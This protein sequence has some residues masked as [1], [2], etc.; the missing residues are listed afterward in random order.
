MNA[1]YT[2]NRSLARHRDDVATKLNVLASGL[3]RTDFR[4]DEITL[5][6]DLKDLFDLVDHGHARYG[7]PR[8]NGGLFNL[9]AN[10]FLETKA[11][12]D[13]Y[14]ARVLDQLGRA[15][16]PG[17]PDLG[18]FRVDY[19]D[20]AIQQLGSVYE[21]LL[22]L[23]PRYANEEMR[24]V[25]STRGG[26][27]IEKVI[28]AAE[29]A[30]RGFKPTGTAYPADSIYL[31]T[32]KGERRK[33]GSYYT[34]DHIVGR[35]VD[36]ALGSRCRELSEAIGRE[37]AEARTALETAAAAER[38]QWEAK[39]QALEGSFVDRVLGLKVLDPAM[40]SG[41]F[42]IRACQ[43][44]A[45]EIAT[46]PFTS[47]PAADALN[48]DESTITY[49]KRRVAE[50]C[51]YGVD[52]NRM[53][54]ELAKLALWL[55]TVA[56]DAP[57]T[58]LDHH[59]RHGDS[60]IGARVAHLGGVPGEE[61]ILQGQFTEEVERALPSLLEP[62][63]EIRGLPSDTAEHVK[64]KGQIFERRFLPAQDRFEKT[65]NLWCAEVLESGV[66]T[67]EQYADTVRAIG[68][69]QQF[70]T[71]LRSEWC[72]GALRSL[73][74]KGV[75]PF[76]WEL[77]YPDVFLSP[78]DRRRS[79]FDVIIGNPP[80]DVLAELEAGREI[81]HLK[82]HIGLDPSL[83]PSVVGKNNL[84]KV[85]ICRAV[86]LLADGGYLGFIV[87]MPLL[88][89]EQARGIRQLLLAS[90]AFSEIH[91]FPQK[92][93]A[94]RRVFR[95]AK[96]STAV[97]V[98]RKMR[99]EEKDG[100]SQ[101]RSHV[102]PAQFIESESPSLVLDES[103]IELY[104]PANL[105]ILSCSQADWDLAKRIVRRPGIGRLGRFCKSYQGE[106]N[107]TNEGKRAGVLYG[108]PGL[109]RKLVLRGSN[110]CLYVLRKASQGE[111]IYI[112]EA[113][114]HADRRPDSKSFHTRYA[115]IGFQRSSPQNNYRRLIA[116]YVPAGEFCFDTV[117][118]IP[119]VN[120]SRLSPNFLLALLNSK[121]LDWY[122]RLGST[123]SKV[124][125]YQ[126][127]N[128]PCP[129]FREAGD[130]EDRIL[131]G[132]A[133]AALDNDPLDAVSQVAPALVT[134]PFGPAAL[135]LLEALAR[136]LRAFEERRGII[137]RSA[138][139]ALCA[140][141]EPYQRALDLLIFRLAGLSESESAGIEERLIQM[142]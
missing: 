4:R 98:Y 103:S 105:T 96:L 74:E 97:F 86:E 101:F 109:G 88:G 100:N 113:A 7:V 116:A 9:E 68:K 13:W 90:G 110:V 70:V 50:S 30:P 89:D 21:G 66:I 14:V 138:R 23:W 18:L 78:H 99:G 17:R 76:H 35:I 132:R 26:A 58:F 127:N 25:R 19:R 16:Q 82:R 60:I 79:G 39:L 29:R 118:Y 108:E 130:R 64:Q 92:D 114:F 54:V 77:A 120:T 106:V 107:E 104:D 142:L 45:E 115:R 15:P 69:R 95:D 84:Y 44:L 42:L 87:P 11:L 91:G 53:A 27:R 10:S 36:R 34:P 75:T 141:A 139:A 8:Y 65:A 49:W 94:S 111:D 72:Q 22:E 55:E 3:D 102:H 63:A 136:R 38:Q 62:L 2:R 61:G 20:L 67:P 59:L 24:V 73:E 128:L 40:G 48:S 41:H 31:A 56:A 43:Y 117:S 122:F 28:A 112:D 131:V 133:R 129:V 71:L 81:A 135:D 33:S 80:Y 1:T 83:R 124:N 52:A 46:H 51:L 5:W 123:N 47:D 37:I 85:F 125:E 119:Q 126:F 140:E 134:A 12:P 137:S 6:S 57:L 93:D 32:E 121:L